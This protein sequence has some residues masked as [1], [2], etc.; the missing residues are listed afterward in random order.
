[1]VFFCINWYLN[2]KWLKSKYYVKDEN[3]NK[4][5]QIFTFDRTILDKY[6]NLI[7]FFLCIIKILTLIFLAQIP[8][9]VS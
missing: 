1:M 6:F 3:K 5:E 7:I 4:E 2:E 9:K 8:Y